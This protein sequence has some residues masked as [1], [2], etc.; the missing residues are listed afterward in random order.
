MLTPDPQAFNAMPP[1]NA[2]ETFL[3][4]QYFQAVD[5]MIKVFAIRPDDKLLFLSDF[6]IDPRVFHAIEGIARARG[7]R[8]EMY[9]SSNWNTGVFP[10]ELKPVYEKATL[11]VSTWFASIGDA[12]C[13]KVR[14]DTGQR[15][16][17]MT[18]FRNIDVLKTPQA[19][20]PAELV[21][22]ITRATRDMYPKGESFALKITDPRGTDW[23]ANFTPE[24]REN[25]LSSNRWRG[26]TTAEEAG[27]YVHWVP[28][29]GPNVYD[30]T[31]LGK[32]MDR[33]ATRNDVNGIV[34]PQSA[35]GFPKP[36][37]DQIG[38]VFENDRIV[39]VRGIPRESLEGYRGMMYG[40]LLSPGSEGRIPHWAS[41]QAYIAL[42][43]LMTAA[44]LLGIDTCAIEGFAPAEYDSI[45]GLKEQGYASV[46]CCA[47]GY[48]SAGDK[49]AD[50]AKVRFPN[51][52]LIKT[53]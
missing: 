9:M 10:E 47:L 11:V 19:R 46:V 2:N 48:R 26:Q 32:K 1:V 21:G 22:E 49:Y 34:Y 53:V 15:T 45:L 43:N 4:A 31:T 51:S 13:L 7:V 16:V 52:D 20:F 50:L 38:V 24:M 28:T 17:K 40:S 41:L 23:T 25:M 37:S 39:E 36:F 42:G 30:R 12:Y 3:T 14:K 35:V 6:L 8:P 5:N 18:Y 33:G 44:S 29:H 27:A